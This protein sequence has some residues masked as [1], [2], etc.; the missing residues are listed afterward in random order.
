MIAAQAKPSRRGV[1]GALAI[2]P[3]AAALPAMGAASIG[4]RP[5]DRKLA[6]YRS[7][8]GS[9]EAY[10]AAVYQPAWKRLVEIAGKQ[11]PLSFSLTA[12]NG[13]VATYHMSPA[14]M[15]DYAASP[16]YAHQ[17]APMRD[18]WK[19]WKQRDERAEQ[20]VGWPAIVDRQDA[21]D[22]VE[23]RTQAALIAEPAPDHEALAVKL[24]VAL[25]RVSG[26][27]IDIDR[28]ALLADLARL[29]P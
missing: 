22:E 16:I 25:T 14:D 21:L 7:A 4:V 24:K 13:Q 2:A 11:P 15:D 6:E 12:R 27:L 26:E 10:N 8:L 17:A 9:A 5:W 19:S 20:V 23:Y 28:D 1:L 29:V 3:A 18:A